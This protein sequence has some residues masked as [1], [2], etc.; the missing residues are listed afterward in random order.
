VDTLHK[1][2]K[3]SLELAAR[4]YAVSPRKLQMYLQDEQ[5]SYRE[6]FN[7]MRKELSKKL[8]KNSE[9]RACGISLI[10]G[11]SDQSAFNHAFKRWTG[12]TSVEYRK[13]FLSS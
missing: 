2:R 12:F 5:T 4:I 11:F 9:S 6:I 13:S 8:L 3:P 7:Q 1:G 10:L